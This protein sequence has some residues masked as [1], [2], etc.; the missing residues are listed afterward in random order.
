MHGVPEQI[1]AVVFDKA[2]HLPIIKGWWDLYEK[3]GQLP[4]TCVPKNGV[5]ILRNERP[6]ASCFLYI[7]DSR[8]CHMDFCIV[9]P[10]IGAGKR[11]AFL[12]TVIEEGI[13]RAKFLIGDDVVIWSLTDHAVVARVYQEK[14]FKSLGEGDCFAYASDETDIKF[15]Q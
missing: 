3:S 8:M 1:E 5:V 10:D 15:L 7:N 14:G 11:V 12:R 4:E 9:D 13:K 2:K 6:V